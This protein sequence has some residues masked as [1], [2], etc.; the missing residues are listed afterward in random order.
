[1]IRLFEQHNIRKQRE[2]DGIWSFITEEGAE[3][4]DS[5]TGVLGAESRTLELQR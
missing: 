4:K 5:R 2:L 3:Y 1:M